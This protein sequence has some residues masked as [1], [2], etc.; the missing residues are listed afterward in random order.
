LKIVGDIV[1][2]IQARSTTLGRNECVIILNS[3]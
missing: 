3:R 2:K 1:K